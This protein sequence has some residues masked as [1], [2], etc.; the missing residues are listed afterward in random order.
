M[1]GT[2]DW[3]IYKIFFVNDNNK[4]KYLHKL[5]YRQY[6]SDTGEYRSV[7]FFKQINVF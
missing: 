5:Q 7:T 3:K 6:P 1:I 2:S 4:N